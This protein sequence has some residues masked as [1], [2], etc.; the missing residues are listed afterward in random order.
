MKLKGKEELRYT[1]SES[2]FNK[3]HRV[4]KH[5]YIAEAELKVPSAPEVL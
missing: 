4:P 2:D 3:P 1:S 5:K